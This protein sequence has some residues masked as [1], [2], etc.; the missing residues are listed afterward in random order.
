MTVELSLPHSF[1]DA[2]GQ[3]FECTRMTY[4]APCRQLAKGLRN[5]RPGDTLRVPLLDAFS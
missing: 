1:I 3:E 2:S 4:I 5:K